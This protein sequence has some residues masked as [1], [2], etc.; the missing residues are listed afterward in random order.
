MVVLVRNEIFMF[1]FLNKFVIKVASLLMYVKVA[2]LFV[3]GCVC[4]A[5]ICSLDVSGGVPVRGVVFVVVD[6]EGIVM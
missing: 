5:A 2:H 3:G 4:V 6:W 1:A